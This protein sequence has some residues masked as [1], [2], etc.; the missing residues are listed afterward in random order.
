MT[1]FQSPIKNVLKKVSKAWAPP[2]RLTVTEW[3]DEYRMLSPE[4]SAEA[5]KYYSSR[6]PYQKG[7]MD[8]IS[9]RKVERVVLMTSA[10]IGKSEMLLNMTGYVI[11]YAPA[12]TLVMLPTLSMA[13]AWSKER[14]APMCRDTPVLRDKIK[15][16]RSRDSNNTTLNKQFPGGFISIIASNS[17]ASISSRPIKNVF[18]DEVDRFAESAGSEGSPV[19]LA[20]ART[21]TFAGSKI[22]MV[23]TPTIKDYSPIEINY[24]NSSKNEYYVPC[25]E[26]NEKQTLTW[27]QVQYDPE[28][29]TVAQIACKHCGSLIDESKK[30]WMLK[31]GEWRSG[32][33]N[34]KIQ[35]FHINE[36]YSP[37]RSWLDTAV[38]YEEARSKP[39]MMKVWVNTSLGL[40]YEG[41]AE[42]LDAVELQDKAENY[43]EDLLPE[44]VLCLTAGADVQMDRIECSVFGWSGN[45]ETYVITHKIFWGLTT[46]TGVW[47]EFNEYLLS[48]FETEDG[49]KMRI[50]ST[51]VDTGGSS[52]QSVYYFLKGKARRRV[53]GVKGSSEQGRPIVNK[54]TFIQ[55]YNIPLYIVGTDTAK[56]WIFSRLKADGLIHFSES[57]D[58][59]YYAQL[60]SEKKVLVMRN[61]R[62]AFRYQQTRKR[63]ETLDCFVYGLTAKEILNP[64][65]EIL[66]QKK[67]ADP[68]SEKPV[69]RKQRPRLRGKIL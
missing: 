20:I 15:D 17:P 1:G 37:W 56:D 7:I 46:D 32:S 9:D 45:D 11:S 14:L 10:Q 52:T 4:A 69:A 28:N 67:N 33:D 61:G 21:R 2:P 40:P 54:P 65:Y 5:G 35:G 59:E 8:A 60:T 66:E 19:N 38:D 51:C 6:A 13:Q 29:M 62:Q 34:P 26:C 27:E 24:E 12:P 39:E 48:I 44:S 58:E 25:P 18:L 55:R 36:L 3:S 47:R 30:M 41:E 16:P 68:E 53:F 23:S 49:R 50:A 57:L 31:N 64:N 43:N 42:K 22:V 63:N